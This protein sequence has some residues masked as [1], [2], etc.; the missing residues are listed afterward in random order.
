VKAFVV[1]VNGE[2]LCTAGIGGNG[3]LTT[4][5]SWVGRGRRGHF[6]M[7][8]GGLDSRTDQHIRW[9]VPAVRVGDEITVRV[10][11]AGAVDPPAERY[12]HSD[13]VSRANKANRG[14]GTAAERRG[15]RPKAARKSRRGSA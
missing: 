3:V 7:H 6:H 2:R 14:G 15:K 12:K 8:V 4:I 5:V 11:E 10:V 1:L 13:V 9:E